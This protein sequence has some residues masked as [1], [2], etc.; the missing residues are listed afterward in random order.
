MVKPHPFQLTAAGLHFLAMVVMLLDHLG[1]TLFPAL[2]WLR[3]IG[4]IAFPIFAFLLVEGYFHTGNLK[5]Y[6]LR[7][8]LFALLA[9]VPFDLMVSGS[10][11]APRSQNV[12]W[13]LLL[14]L[15]LI[16][17]HEQTQKIG[18]L[19]LRLLCSGGL[20][21]LATFL[22]AVVQSNYGYAGLFMILVFYCFRGRKWFHFAGQF[23]GLLYINTQ[24][25]SSIPLVIALPGIHLRLPL[26][27]LAL[28]ALIPIWLYRGKA[29]CRSKALRRLNYFFY[30]VH[31]LI[32]SILRMLLQFGNNPS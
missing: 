12:L 5:R 2:L 32:L 27:S 17:L 29:G 18:I 28:L 23:L 8:F 26:Q 14:G 6:A 24:V 21:V 30:P 10:V 15:G 7:L 13:T 19:W 11:Y 22:G 9:E 25:L 3:G 16:F 31:M 1:H 20:V 4:R